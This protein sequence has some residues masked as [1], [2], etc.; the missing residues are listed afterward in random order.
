[1]YLDENALKVELLGRG[2]A[3]LDTGTHDSLLDAASFVATM[4]HR[5][6]LK[7]ACIEEI[8][9][10]LGYIDQ[11]QLLVLGNRCKNSDYGKY[12]IKLSQEHLY[13]DASSKIAAN[14]NG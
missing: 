2:T 14:I 4:E 7:I 10:H 12:L 11:A 9:Y 13:A 3:W 5:Q 6:G 8:A 1:M